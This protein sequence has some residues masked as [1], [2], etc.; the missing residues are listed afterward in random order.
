MQMD[1]SWVLEQYDALTLEQEE[2]GPDDFDRLG[3]IAETHKGVEIP[4]VMG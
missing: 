1:T 4:V 2:D 3:R